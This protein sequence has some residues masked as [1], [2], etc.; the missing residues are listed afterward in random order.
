M[1]DLLP[2]SYAVQA[3]KVQ[4]CVSACTPTSVLSCLSQ[5]DFRKEFARFAVQS[6][7]AAYAYQKLDTSA[8]GELVDT[9]VLA[10]LKTYLGD[11]LTS[12]EL[13]G[14]TMFILTTADTDQLSEGEKLEM[15]IAGKR[16]E[17][18]SISVGPG[19]GFCRLVCDIFSMLICKSYQ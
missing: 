2:Q 16:I 10:S 3:C 9:E 6:I 18:N 7:V 4:V 15:R 11:L 19:I 5:V 14:L 1:V 12:E 8:N 13:L 17:S